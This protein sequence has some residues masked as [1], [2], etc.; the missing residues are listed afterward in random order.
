MSVDNITE[1]REQLLSR[2]GEEFK[3]LICW[4]GAG[5]WNTADKIKAL[6]R[7]KKMALIRKKYIQGVTCLSPCEN[8]GSAPFFGNESVAVGHGKAEFKLQAAVSVHRRSLI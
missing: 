7:G 3:I 4:G 6:V 1:Y 2:I 5:S 8:F